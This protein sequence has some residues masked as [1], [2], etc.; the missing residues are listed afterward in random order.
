M[1]LAVLLPAPQLENYAFSV[2]NT[3]RDNAVA[4]KIDADEKE[5]LEKMVNET[6]EWLDH[7]Q[8][9]EEEEFEDKRKELESAAS[10]IFAKMYQAGGAPPGGMP[11]GMPDMP[12]AAPRQGPTVE[13]VD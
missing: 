11:G 1:S 3:L 12:E 2:R 13:E 9:A 5:K 7:N 10:P 4:D 8:L 6:I